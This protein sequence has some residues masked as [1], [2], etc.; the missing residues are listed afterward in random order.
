MRLIPALVSSLLLLVAALPAVADEAR[1]L[2]FPDVHGDRVA[3]VYAGDVWVASSDGGQARRLTSHEGL[4]VFPKFSPDGR[5]IAFSGE[6]SGT[7]QVHTIPVDGGEPRQL[8]FYN[9]VGQLPPRGG[10]DHRVLGWTPD[11]ER[12]LFRANRLPW[13]VR[14]GRPYTVP[15]EGGME[16][17]LVVPE[18]GGGMLSP[19][20]TRYVY[21]PI[22]REF[23]TWKRHEGGRAQDVWIFD[24]ENVTAEQLTDW[25]GTDNQPLWIGDTIYY[26]SDRTGSGEPGRLNL[27]AYDLAS[28][29]HRQVT[30]HEDFDVLW[31]SASRQVEGGAAVVYE[32]GGWLY[33]FDPAT[34]ETRKLSIELT[35]D[36]P[37]ARPEY[38]KVAEL[39]AAADLSPSGARALFDA[40]GDLFTVP[41]EHGAVRNLTRTQGVRERDPAWSPDGR[42]LAYLSDATGEYELY[43]AP[44]DGSGEARRLTSGSDSWLMA[45]AWSPDSS[46]IAFADREQRL[47]Y[48]DVESG[49]IVDVDSSDTNDFD[50]YRWSPDSGWLAY[51]KVDESQFA[52]IW[53]YSVES[54][55]PQRL[56]EPTTNDYSPVFSPD[57]EYLYFLSD[58]DW[59]LT[60]SGFEFDFLHTE[61]TRV[62]AALLAPDSPRLFV[63]K[64]DE[65]KPEEEDGPAASGDG[66]SDDDGD[67]DS[68]SDSDSDDGTVEVSL[69]PEGFTDRV[70]V[71]PVPPAAYQALEPVEG[72]LLW[73]VGQPP[74]TK[75][76][77]FS[78]EEEQAKDVLSGIE[79]FALSANGKKLLYAAGGTWGIVDAKPGQK[80][81]A[82]KL[83]LSGMEMRVDYPAE[84]S[85]IFDD[86]WR[87][88]RDWFYDPNLHGVDWA[89]MRELYR[90]MVDHLGHRADLDYILGEMGGE[91]DAGHYYVN[92]GD[93]PRPERVD[94]GLLG[95]ELEADPSG[96]F[97][98]AH[99]LP[100]ENWHPSF[101]SPLTE[102]GVD[103]S[104]GDYL[105]AVDGR[106]AREVDN[107]YQLLERKAGDTVTLTVNDRP[108]AEGA[109]E[110]RIRPI[111]R[112]TDLRYL[113]WVAERRH[114]VDE[115][116]GGRIGYIHLPN[117]AVEGNREL[118][119]WFYPQAHKDALIL[120]A[121]YN[122]G[123][124]IPDTMIELLTRP[125]LSFWVRRGIVP[126]ATPG[127]ANT[128]PKAALINGYSS[129]GGDAFPFYFRQQGVGPL[130][131]TRT[132][133]G[134]I[135]ISGNPGFADGG[136]VAVPTFRFMTPE[137]EWAVEDEGV[138]PDIEV[139]DRPDLVAEGQ[140]PTLERAVEV[141][142]EELEQNPPAE[143]EVPEP[144]TQRRDG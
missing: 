130:I 104:A 62:Y 16:E 58:R 32:N 86:A 68:D 102:P 38:R 91:L 39:I 54:G 41:V 65:E 9:D 137:G 63:P 79:G 135:G 99:V 35:D 14:M 22:D 105:I 107:A 28:G 139:V 8:T 12:V 103:V 75:L 77:H 84:W 67:S 109:R 138:A 106:D 15:A 24:L 116:S 33:R 50:H 40:R 7:R 136:S 18:S 108:D 124:F 141:L 70:V 4:E 142:L 3:F 97:R 126:F 119:K 53:A 13:G 37:W 83:D 131:G 51:T 17:P 132:W 101:R 11:G 21:T 140:D 74:E 29:E 134:L 143:L 60:F 1:L 6:Y 110:V 81:G 44:A 31:P 95:A 127:F 26:S 43:V 52:S 36:R 59:N 73:I 118:H 88:T 82:G 5:T 113:E 121:R 85:Q 45:P 80:A 25:R 123:G 55:A 23:R 69:K 93:M 117:T 133:G 57:G 78:F 120:D 115:L 128:G 66:D 90:P 122:G 10:F 76:Q 71:L 111:E 92:S 144:P 89:R 47:R 46:K 27:W 87:I 125:R 100:G 98:I 42:W 64:S 2:R 61:P 49:R 96:Y 48:A 20:G 34:E 19:D 56:T 114:R 72:G 129:S 30:F 112:E 94:N